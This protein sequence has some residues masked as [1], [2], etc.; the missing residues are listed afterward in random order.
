M[1]CRRRAHSP[2]L[3]TQRQVRW[4][5][6]LHT[7]VAIKGDLGR[8]RPIGH[9]RLHLRAEPH[10]CTRCPPAICLLH[11]RRGISPTNACKAIT[12]IE[13]ENLSKRYG[14]KLDVDGLNFVIQPGI[15]TLL[16]G[17]VAP[18]R[19]LEL[20]TRGPRTRSHCHGRVRPGP[21]NEHQPADA[22]TTRVAGQAMSRTRIPRGTK[23]ILVADH[24][25]GPPVVPIAPI[26][27]RTTRYHR[28][29]ARRPTC[30]GCCPEPGSV[31][32]SV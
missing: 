13:L 10:R 23:T 24:K 26:F 29:V 5:R 25:I 8:P 21:P 9:P 20:G 18:V 1:R 28:R 17:A 30:G 2:G 6:F 31:V 11:R 7:N 14:T 16:V 19:T 15:V 27:L 12:M 32:S 22:R 4:I 3:R